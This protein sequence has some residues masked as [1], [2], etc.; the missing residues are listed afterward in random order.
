[1]KDAELHLQIGK[2]YS[3]LTFKNLFHFPNL[4]GEK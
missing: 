4:M 1:M 3:L 2:C